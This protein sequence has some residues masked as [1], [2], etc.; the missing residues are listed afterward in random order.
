LLLCT[1]TRGLHGPVAVRTG[2]SCT[3]LVARAQA[4]PCARAGCPVHER[5]AGR[6][7]ACRV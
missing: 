2:C 3:P 6:T 4:A 7:G 5:A 1:A